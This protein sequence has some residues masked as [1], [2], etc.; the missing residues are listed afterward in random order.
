[1]ESDTA[2]RGHLD[3]VL[4]RLLPRLRVN[5]SAA[6]QFNHSMGTVDKATPDGLTEL[7]QPRDD[8]PL[9]GDSAAWS[10]DDDGPA[11]IVNPTATIAAKAAQ[12][13]A[14]IA[15][16]RRRRA[17]SVASRTF[18]TGAGTY[19]SGARNSSRSR[20]SRLSMVHLLASHSYGLGLRGRFVISERRR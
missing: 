7:H 1:M 2:V 19:G 4:A 14:L 15:T 10:P 13:V 12:P 18:K 16:T 5:G 11:A 8:R 17:R 9:R 6:L 3:D 20:D